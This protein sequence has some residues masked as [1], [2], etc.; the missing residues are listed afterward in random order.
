M[1]SCKNIVV[2]GQQL[3]KALR[4]LAKVTPRNNRQ[5]NTLLSL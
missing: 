4:N 3:K 5:G 2:L 1:R